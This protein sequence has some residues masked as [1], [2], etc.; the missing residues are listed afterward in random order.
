MTSG[1]TEG[2]TTDSDRVIVLVGSLSAT[3]LHSVM[4]RVFER[5]VGFFLEA[6]IQGGQTIQRLLG[7]NVSPE[8][9]MCIN[10]SGQSLKK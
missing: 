1:G 4:G 6:W 7:S 2:P 3:V 9:G 10:N 5:I 8:L